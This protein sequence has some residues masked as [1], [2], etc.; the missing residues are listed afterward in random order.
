MRQAGLTILALLCF[1]MAG[2]LFFRSGV[3][4]I[5]PGPSRSADSTPGP[6]VVFMDISVLQTP[7]GD[8]AVNEEVWTTADE[9]ILPV[10]LQQ[11]L[12]QHGLRVGLVTG[13]SDKLLELLTSKRFNPDARRGFRQIDSP[14]RTGNSA[15]VTLATGLPVCEFP[16]HLEDDRTQ[17]VSRSNANCQFQVIPM[18]DA[19]GKITLQFTPQIEFEDREKWNRLDP[20]VALAVQGNRSTELF[21]ELRWEVTLGPD[22]YVLVGTRLDRTGSLGHRFLVTTDS[23]RPIQRLVAI[24]AGRY[25]SGSKNA[26]PTTLA[27]QAASN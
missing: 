23:E 15:L 11:K 8:R 20:T 13:R 26:A 12:Q 14:T 25:R 27:S 21:S 2:C 9:Q 1:G 17:T 4:S 10:P 3:N 24:R 22:E 7:V 5:W 18:L 16:L 6:D 19:G